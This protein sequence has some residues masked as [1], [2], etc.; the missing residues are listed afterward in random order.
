MTVTLTVEQ[1]HGFLGASRAKVCEYLWKKNC[2]HQHYT[3]NEAMCMISE[4]TFFAATSFVFFE[5]I[6]FYYPN[7]MQALYKIWF[8]AHR[9]VVLLSYKDQS[10]EPV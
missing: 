1:L 10:V 3:E 5:I 6:K 4:P 8:L 2:F 7:L 9:N